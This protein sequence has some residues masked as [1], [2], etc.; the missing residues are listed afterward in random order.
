MQH[1]VPISQT[2]HFLCIIKASQLI[3]SLGSTHYLFGEL[4]EKIQL[5]RVTEGGTYS[6]LCV[7]MNWNFKDNTYRNGIWLFR[8][9][10][11]EITQHH[12]YKYWYFDYTHRT[13]CSFF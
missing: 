5:L 4:C 13:V 12:A 2:T 9:Y 11:Q 3:L 6:N 7:L 8:L 1:S 10:L